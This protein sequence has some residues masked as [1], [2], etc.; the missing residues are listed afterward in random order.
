[1]INSIT[2]RNVATYDNEGIQINNLKKSKF[3]LWN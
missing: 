3:Y 1:M 2:I